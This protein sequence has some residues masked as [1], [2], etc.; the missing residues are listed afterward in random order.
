[1]P[2]V[3][4]VCAHPKREEIDDALLSGSSFRNVSRC[5]GTSKSTVERHRRDHVR[6]A[7]MSA[8][9]PHGVQPDDA[10][11]TAPPWRPGTP[12]EDTPAASL[13]LSD[14]PDS[15]AA[16]EWRSVPIGAESQPENASV[17]GRLVPI[18]NNADSTAMSLRDGQSLP[19][20]NSGGNSVIEDPG[21]GP[22][23]C[24][25]CGTQLTT[26][27]PGVNPHK[28]GQGFCPEC[29]ERKPLRPS[30]TRRLLKVVGA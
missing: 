1:V 29:G 13:W 9:S 10:G 5:F 8:G 16:N 12:M 6:N 24:I 23:H 20:G 28:A 11:Q 21:P 27:K 3:C 25:D 14:G 4:S 30:I 7:P 19:S 22:F 26:Y 2:R 15:D 18:Q 17:A